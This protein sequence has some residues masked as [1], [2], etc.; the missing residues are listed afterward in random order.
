MHASR[1]IRLCTKD[2]LC[3]FVCPTGATDTENGQ[4]DFSKCTGC[5]ACARSCISHA[6]AMIP[7]AWEYPPQQKKA[8]QVVSSI[9]DLADSK[10][11]QELVARG[12]SSRTTD[13]I[14]RQLA[15]TL[16][17]SNRK[18]AEDLYREAGYMLPQSKN[19][20][21]FLSSLLDMDLDAE[22]KSAVKELLET[23]PVN[24]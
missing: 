7:D 17:T 10:V 18:M 20:H 1:N 14:Q 13:P 12:I 6:I 16:A 22:S 9:K 15:D 4:I 2:C 21:A 11:R 19:V 23:I 24:D 8:P 3:L 5:G